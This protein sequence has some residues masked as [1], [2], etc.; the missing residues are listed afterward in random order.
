M[1]K[2][3]TFW[4]FVAALS[5]ANAAMAEHGKSVGGLTIEHAWARA[6]AG[7]AK[8]AAAYLT[9]KNVGKVDDR[10]T[11]VTASSVAG[12]AMLHTTVMDG[13]VMKMRHVDGITVKAG[14]T[15]TLEPGGNHVMLMGLTA[16][17]KEGGR[18]PLTLTFEK[19]GRVI[20]E[21]EIK[22]PGAM[23]DGHGKHQ[24]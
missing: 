8:T 4:V 7:P 14:A 10:L 5:I 12:M 19:A 2:L 18:F 16:P 13:N 22:A 15:A 1:R 23:G 17:L 9:I 20:V 11:A 21:V 24:H 6:S 3:F